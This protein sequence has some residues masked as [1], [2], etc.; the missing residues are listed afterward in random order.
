MRIGF[1]AMPWHEEIKGGQG[2]G[3]SHLERG[4]GTMGDFLQMTDAVHHRE[5]GLDQPQRIPQPPITQVAI[6][7]IALFGMERRIAEHDHLIV[8]G[9]DQRMRGGTVGM[10]AG[11]IPTDDQAQLIKEQTKFAADNPAMIRFP[12][13]PDLLPTPAFAHRMEQLYAIAI[14]DPQDR[15]G[16]QEFVRPGPMRGQQ[17]KQP[18]ARAGQETVCAN[19][20]AASDK[21]PDFPLL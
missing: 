2:K 13:A 10:G 19:P 14:D 16:G 18:R 15:G 21:R 20:G 11:P 1:E 4:P 17:A 6:R 12:L 8:E 3:K 5:H 7:R 9:F